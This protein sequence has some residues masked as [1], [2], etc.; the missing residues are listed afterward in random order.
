MAILGNEKVSLF[1]VTV[2]AWIKKDDTYLIHQRALNDRVRPGERAIPWGKLE[3]DPGDWWLEKNLSKEIEEEV[4]LQIKNPKL[5]HNYIRPTF[6]NKGNRL[7]LMYH[8]ERASGEA[9][10]L[11]DTNDIMRLTIDEL[12]TFTP[13]NEYLQ[14]DI[15]TLLRNI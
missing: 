10:A 11:D 3:A 6:D 1:L 2:W 14:E 15:T 4:W 13:T 5:I 12:K 7:R 9:Q 8:C